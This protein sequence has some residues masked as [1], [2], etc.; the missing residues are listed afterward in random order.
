VE[1]ACLHLIQPLK[2]GEI[3][4]SFLG[5]LVGEILELSKHFEF[6]S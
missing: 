3:Q 1:G 5:F 2:K 4:G 6:I